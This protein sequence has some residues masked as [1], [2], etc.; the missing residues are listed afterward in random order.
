LAHGAF[1]AAAGLAVPG[2]ARGRRIIGN[3]GKS[4]AAITA[5]LARFVFCVAARR[6]A[7]RAFAAA[8]ATVTVEHAELSVV[9]TALDATLSLAH[10]PRTASARHG[11]LSAPRSAPAAVVEASE[12]AAIAVRAARVTV[13]AAIRAGLPSAAAARARAENGDDGSGD[14]NAREDQGS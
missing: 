9:A 3:A 11:A 14:E 4:I 1:E 12:R 2:A 8:G 10:E 6:A 13:Q 7:A 5:R